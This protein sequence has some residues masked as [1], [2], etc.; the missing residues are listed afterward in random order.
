MLKEKVEGV[1]RVVHVPNSVFQDWARSVLD[2]G[3]S[4]F[5]LPGRN[6]T[7]VKAARM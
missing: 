2:P 3:H 7:T 1:G 4:G 6:E 5:S